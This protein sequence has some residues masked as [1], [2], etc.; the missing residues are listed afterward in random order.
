MC[1]VAQVKGTKSRSAREVPQRL[2]EAGIDFAVLYLLSGRPGRP[3]LTNRVM[4]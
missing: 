4:G 2:G 3:R 1:N